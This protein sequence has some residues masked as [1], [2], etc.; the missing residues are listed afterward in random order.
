MKILDICVYL[1]CCLPFGHTFDDGK[2]I[3]CNKKE[4]NE[5]NN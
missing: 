2:C 1:V 4:K 5:Q 3:G